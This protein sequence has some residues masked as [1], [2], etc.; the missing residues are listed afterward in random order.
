M[1][2][3]I[4]PGAAGN[5]SQRVLH[6][7]ATPASAPSM[8]GVE[9]GFLFVRTAHLYACFK[10]PQLLPCEGPLPL[11]I[12]PSHLIHPNVLL[13]TAYSRPSSISRTG[14]GWLEGAAQSKPEAPEFKKIA[15]FI[16]V[17]I[18]SPCSRT[19]KYAKIGQQRYGRRCRSGSFDMAP[20]CLPAIGPSML[21]REYGL[22]ALMYGFE[23]HIA[24]HAISSMV[25]RR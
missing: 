7:F 17:V 14:I 24:C 16:V 2:L 3:P 23:S 9:A 6:L 8:L 5:I 11:R 4:L 19:R 13:S 25:E 20:Q 21:G 10:S 15:A 1:A 18:L 22:A 12:A